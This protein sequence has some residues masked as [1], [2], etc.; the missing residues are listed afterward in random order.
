[1]KNRPKI[2]NNGGWNCLQ[3]VDGKSNEY[4]LFIY[5]KDQ[6]NKIN[7]FGDYEY[8]TPTQMSTTHVIL[9]MEPTS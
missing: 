7:I 9:T 3:V 8:E 4:P 5:K 1:M 6:C 2:E